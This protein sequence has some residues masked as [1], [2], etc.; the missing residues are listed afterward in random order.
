M[1]WH[2]LTNKRFGRLIAKEY[3]GNSKWKCLCD[4][5]NYKTVYA[6]NLEKGDT[7][8]CGCIR[9]QSNDWAFKKHGKSKERLYS[10][11]KAMR[12]RC[13][14]KNDSEYKNYGGR[15]IAVCEEWNT[16]TIFEN[17]AKTHGYNDRLTIERINVNGNYSPENCCW[18]PM[19]DQSK[20]KRNSIKFLVFGENKTVK[21][22]S[23]QYNVKE[24]TFVYRVKKLHMTPEEA[25]LPIDHRRKKYG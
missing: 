11:W 22:I 6:G 16:Y 9:S 21:E 4:C 13:Q 15:G 2:D 10:I 5:G 8:S 24:S 3:L 14:N 20:N 23:K 19:S 12:K 7:K 17:W 25:I 18:I 1:K